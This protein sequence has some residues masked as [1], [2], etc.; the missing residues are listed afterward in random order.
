MKEQMKELYV[1]G[2][3]SHDGHPHAVLTA[4]RFTKVYLRLVPGQLRED[5]DAAMPVFPVEPPRQDDPTR[6]ASGT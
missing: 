4:T 3:A 1:E 2:L 6:L 5:Y